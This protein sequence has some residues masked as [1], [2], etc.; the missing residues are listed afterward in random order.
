MSKPFIVSTFTP[1]EDAGFFNYFA[2]TYEEA[3]ALAE[4]HYLNTGRVVAVERVSPTGLGH[5]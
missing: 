4:W 2:D 1:H 3:V 5:S